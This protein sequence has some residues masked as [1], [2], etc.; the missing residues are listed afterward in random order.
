MLA[1]AAARRSVWTLALVGLGLPVLV[2]VAR[3][4]A[5]GAQPEL[6]ALW[7]QRATLMSAASIEAAVS[8]AADAGFNTL[9]VQVRA[10]GDAMFADAIEPAGFVASPDGDIDPLGE[11]LDRAHNAGLAVHAW[12]NVNLVSSAAQ[13]PISR[14]H[15][16]YRHPEW[17]MVPRDLARELA[18][19]DPKSPTYVGNLARWSR[20]NPRE[21]EG[22]YSSPLQADAAEHTVNVVRD[23]V[24]RYPVDGVHLDYARYPNVDFDYSR[25]AVAAFRDEMQ[26]ELSPERRAELDTAS[27]DDPLVYPETYPEAWTRF[28]R[29]RLTA[30]L[31]RLQSAIRQVRPRAVVSAAV[32]ADLEDA[33]ERRLQDWSTWLELGLLDAVCPLA[34]TVDPATFASQI[35]AARRVPGLHQ[36]WAGIGAFRLTVPGTLENIF[37]AR[38]E[39]VDGIAL[40]SYDSLAPSVHDQPDYLLQVG[41]SA[42]RSELA[43]AA[44]NRDARLDAGVRRGPVRH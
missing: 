13:L 39:G 9:F 26:P 16:A 25:L 33:T 31:M 19:V 35:A 4:D 6:R 1:R 42:F 24:A 5:A 20:G 41:R 23:L 7:V 14:D 2:A 44:L 38:R 40:F 27:A 43:P 36:V 21:L 17:L 28:R 12:V 32:V 18:T 15:I 10:R 29:S 11:I 8:T 30:L 3:L 34:Y 22:L 37:A